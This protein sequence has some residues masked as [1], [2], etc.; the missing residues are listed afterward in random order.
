MF[1]HVTSLRQ[2]NTWKPLKELVDRGVLL[3]ILE[4]GGDRYARA[5]KTQAPPTRSGLRSTSGQEDQS[6]IVECY[7]AGITKGLTLPQSA[8]SQ[9]PLDCISVL[10]GAPCWVV[11]IAIL[12]S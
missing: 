11:V 12:V 1:Q 9:R 10:W 5:S 4:N 7:F 6:I 2:G 8:F 3:K